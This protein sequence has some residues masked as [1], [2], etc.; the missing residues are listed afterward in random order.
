[1]TA[2][3][4]VPGSSERAG[5]KSVAA[6]H[7][8]TLRQDEGRTKPHRSRPAA[9]AKVRVTDDRIE[10]GRRD[11]TFGEGGPGIVGSFFR[12]M[13]SFISA[14]RRSVAKARR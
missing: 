5:Y 10:C 3:L 12:E 9:A 13:D 4:G 11:Y 1:V 8:L 14:R 7:H 2:L 6:A